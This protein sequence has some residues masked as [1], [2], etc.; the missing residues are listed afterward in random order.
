[1]NTFEV[2]AGLPYFSGL[3]V[4]QIESLCRACEVIEVER[5][6]VVIVE[7]SPPEGLLVVVE[8]ILRSDPPDRV[9]RDPAGRRRQGRGSR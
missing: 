7:G 9:R 6:Q 8:G 3:P 5:G 2:L 1:M 4:E